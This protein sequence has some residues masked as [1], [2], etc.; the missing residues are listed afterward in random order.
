MWDDITLR[1]RIYVN[2]ALRK[3]G[4]DTSMPHLAALIDAVA[5]RDPDA[6]RNAARALTQLLLNQL[7]IDVTL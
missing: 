4:G 1:S 2:E 5:A 7:D 3:E 6:A